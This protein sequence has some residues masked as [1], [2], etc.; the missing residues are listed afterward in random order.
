MSP[1]HV[2]RV[3]Y[4]TV[5]PPPGWDTDM[6]ERHPRWAAWVDDG[7]GYHEPLNT[8]MLHEHDTGAPVWASPA[9]RHFLSRSGANAMANELRAMGVDVEVVRSLPVEFESEAS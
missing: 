5:T 6:A 3:V 4:D 1:V 9:R 8:Y 7:D 2:Y